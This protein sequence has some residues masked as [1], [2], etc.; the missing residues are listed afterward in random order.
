MVLLRGFFRMIGF[1]FLSSPNDLALG[2][3]DEHVVGD[4]YP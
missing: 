4:A 1:L 2:L 3:S